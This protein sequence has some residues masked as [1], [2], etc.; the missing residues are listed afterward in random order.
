MR[1]FSPSIRTHN[2]AKRHFL[3]PI[4]QFPSCLMIFIMSPE[5]KQKKNHPEKRENYET[6]T[7]TYRNDKATKRQN[8]NICRPK[9]TFPYHGTINYSVYYYQDGITVFPFP[10]VLLAYVRAGQG[11]TRL[12]RLDL[13]ANR[14]K[15]SGSWCSLRSL[16]S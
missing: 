3:I 16:N 2:T 15:F 4:F 7:R 5:I 14:W 13:E 12:H 6:W 11:L 1:S 10:F 8:Q 9:Q